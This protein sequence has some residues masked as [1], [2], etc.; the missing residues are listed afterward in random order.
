M[1]LTMTRK[2]FATRDPDL[3][4]R[5]VLVLGMGKSGLAAARL[6]ATKGAR[7]TIADARSSDRLGTAVDAARRTGAQVH[8]GGHPASLVERADLIVVSPGIPGT[9]EPLLTA[10]DA[11]IPIWGEVELA[12]RYCRGRIIGIT[13]SNGKSTVTSMVG[14]MLRGAGIRG[15]TGGNLDVPFCDLLDSDGDSAVHA[16]ELSSFQLE[17]VEA[18]SP[19]VAAVLNLTPDHLDRYPDLDAYARAKARL[20]EIQQAGAAAILN[21]DDGSESRFTGSL[22][23]RL[24]RFSVR[25]EPDPGAFVRSGRLVL[26][27]AMGEDELLAVDELPVPGEHNLANALAAALAAR[28]VGCPAAAIDAALRAYRA[29]PHRMEH[30]ATIDGIDFYNDSKA[31]NTDSAARALTSFE[32]G[33][34]H[35]ILGGRD[36]GADWAPLL[37]LIAERRA[38]VLLVGEAAEPL[39]EALAGSVEVQLC[40]TIPRAVERGFTDA[41]RGEVV[42]LSP[43]CA[44]FDQYGNFMER[45]EDFR[46]AVGR[47]EPRERT[48]A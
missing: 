33:R 4:N 21:A 13:G 48:D 11:G 35:L 5:R 46:R 3:R 10:R 41:T 16:V 22:R 8:P 17:N 27:T 7:V 47:L 23:G 37:R 2:P 6:A 34:V 12:A 24:H 38:R 32:P 9:V 1:S 43:A 44:S 42:L 20:L 36:K 45:G 40:G 39:F 31:T 26:R 18:L 19:D 30:V 14:A 29:L 25:R 28:L 15:G